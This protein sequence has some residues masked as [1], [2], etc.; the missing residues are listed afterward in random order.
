[1]NK[2]YTELLNKDYGENCFILAAGPSLYE[3]SKNSF[4]PKLKKYGT[5]ICVN[6]SIMTFKNCDIF[7]S[8]DHLITRW[9][10]Y[11]NLVKNNSKIYRVVRNSWLRYKDEIKNFYI[12]CPRS[13]PEDEIDFQE[14]GKLCY[15]SSAISA[16]DLAIQMKNISKIFLLGIDQCLDK[17]TGYH[18]FWENYPISKQPK[19]PKRIQ[20]NWEQQKKVFKY[21]NMSYKALK[22]FAEYKNV[23][24]YNCNLESNVKVFKK[25]R[26][27][28][29]E[30]II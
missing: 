18:H 24:I 7:I 26:F 20:A 3:I 5:V 8:N 21:N 2:S 10:Y 12:F 23:E 16:L 25:I 1:M 19:V 22:E 15:C 4:F 9:D 13:T 30:N 29:I 27:E 6:S 11:Q 17:K 14:K 28:E